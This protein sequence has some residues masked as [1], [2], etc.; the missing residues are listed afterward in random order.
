MASKNST[1]CA[2]ALLC[3]L[4]IILGCGGSIQVA[5]AAS[6]LQQ[7]VATGGTVM[8]P[9]G[10]ITIDCSGQLAIS[11]TTSLIGAGRDLT[12]L[13]DTCPSGDTIAVD[14]TNPANVRIEELTINHDGGNSDVRAFGGDQGAVPVLKRTLRINSVELT[15]ATNCLVTDGLNQMF[16]EKSNILHCLQDG[17]QIAS[18]SVTMRDNW[19]GENGRNGVSFVDGTAHD[20]NGV[21]YSGFCAPCSGNQYWHNKGHGLVYNVTGISDPRHVQDEIDSNGDVGMVVNGVRVFTFNDSWI[22]T[23]QNGGMTVGDTAIGTVIIGN[24]FT[25][26]FGPNIV[27]RESSGPLRVT[28]N[29][30]SAPH[31]P[32]DANING[33]CVSLNTQ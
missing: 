14:L 5:Q 22:G 10:T 21:R 30:S 12:I 13:H 18:F 3:V 23:N 6:T 25:N 29:T 31:D 7:Q 24:T 1:F 20:E 16:L 9:A 8:L 33:T 28:G 4:S 15:G 11:K 19:F 27:V 17:A 2:A 32:C 26:N